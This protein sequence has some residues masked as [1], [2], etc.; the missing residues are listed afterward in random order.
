MVVKRVNDLKTINITI[1]YICFF[2][3]LL[4]IVLI[5]ITNWLQENRLETMEL[6]K[7]FIY[8]EIVQ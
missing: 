5:P 4:V 6:Y 1:I 8:N 7:M 2:L 3:F